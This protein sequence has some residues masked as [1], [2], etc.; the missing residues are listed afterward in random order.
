MLLQIT[1][2]SLQMTTMTMKIMTIIKDAGQKSLLLQIITV[3][4]QMMTTIM[5]I[6]MMTEMTFVV[7]DH[8]CVFA[9]DG[10]DV[11]PL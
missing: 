6:V 7:A 11:N 5:K 2:V 1:T 4:L 3:S 10:T 9:D 8:H